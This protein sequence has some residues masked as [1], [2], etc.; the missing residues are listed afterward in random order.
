MGRAVTS[1]TQSGKPVFA[2]IPFLGPIPNKPNA[3]NRLF[4]NPFRG[5]E[6]LY[7]SYKSCSLTYKKKK[8]SVGDYKLTNFSLNLISILF[9]I[10]FS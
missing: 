8:N 10:R 3:R 6:L 4:R 2:L 7:I 5:N 1:Q 9:L